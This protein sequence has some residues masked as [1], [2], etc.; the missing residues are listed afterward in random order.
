MITNLKSYRLAKE[1]KK[2]STDFL[3]VIEL[4]QRG[5]KP[6]LQYTPIAKILS[7]LKNQEAILKAHLNT[8]EKI[9]A[10]KEVVK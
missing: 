6:F 4:S 3:K 5:L 7:E 8:A 2:D 1:Y 10:K 9:L